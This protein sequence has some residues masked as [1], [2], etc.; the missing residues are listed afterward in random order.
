MGRQGDRPRRE[1]CN[2]HPPIIRK[3]HIDRTGALLQSAPQRPQTNPVSCE[4]DVALGG[5][6]D[7]QTGRASLRRLARRCGLAAAR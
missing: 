4:D 5:D 3:L 2:R 6:L 1:E 7:R